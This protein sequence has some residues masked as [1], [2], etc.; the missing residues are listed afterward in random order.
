MEQILMTELFLISL[1]FSALA[2]NWL[3]PLE[4]KLLHAE[5]IKNA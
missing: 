3:S 5:P 1:E 4:K 2:W